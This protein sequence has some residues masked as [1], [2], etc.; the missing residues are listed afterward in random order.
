MW[1]FA[2]LTCADIPCVGCLGCEG[3]ERTHS[4][5]GCGPQLRLWGLSYQSWPQHVPAAAGPPN[6]SRPSTGLWLN[7]LPL[8]R[9]RWG[10]LLARPGGDSEAV[11]SLGPLAARL[12]MSTKRVSSGR[13]DGFVVNCFSSCERWPLPLLSVADHPIDDP[14]DR[15]VGPSVATLL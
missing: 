10:W 7:L 8:I 11:Q 9:M 2:T 6:A 13:R 12:S 15:R 4:R 5:Q 3:H 14:H 1:L